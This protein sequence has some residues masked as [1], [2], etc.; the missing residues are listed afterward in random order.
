[1]S[2]FLG[3]LVPSPSSFCPFSPISIASIESR[4]W[5][6]SHE[7]KALSG[8]VDEKVY[9]SSPT[10]EESETCVLKVSHNSRQWQTGSAGASGN[11]VFDRSRRP[12]GKINCLSM[13]IVF[14][15]KDP[16]PTVF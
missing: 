8:T 3:Y 12:S 13:D 2:S 16:T 7:R 9:L 11:V 1:M 4:I 10:D 14:A 6:Y 15:S 5:F